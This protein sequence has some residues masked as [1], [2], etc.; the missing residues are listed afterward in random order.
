MSS[1]TSSRRNLVPARNQVYLAYRRLD[2]L[3]QQVNSLT[4][5]VNAFMMRRS[6]GPRDHYDYALIHVLAHVSVELP[7][8]T[9]ALWRRQ[10]V[11]TELAAAIL[12]C[13]IVST[14]QLG[15]LLKRLAGHTVDGLCIRR[16]GTS[17]EGVVWQL[18]QE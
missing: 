17:R 8:T 18:L 9:S 14:K 12:D 3:E 5:T 6:S 16:I 4:A 1:A 10:A 2:A 7:F 11:D 13:D 15:K